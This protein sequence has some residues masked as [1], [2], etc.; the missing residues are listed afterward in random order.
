MTQQH[1][2]QR[3]T[4]SELEAKL[5]RQEQTVAEPERRL[6]RAEE[7]KREDRKNGR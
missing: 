5:R 7:H 6:G 3:H 2:Q 4:V 1:Q